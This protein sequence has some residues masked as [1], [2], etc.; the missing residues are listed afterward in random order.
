MIGLMPP[1]T[2]APVEAHHAEQVRVVGDRDRGHAQRLRP[3]DEGADPHHAVHEREL[4]MQMQVHEAGI[5]DAPRPGACR[6]SAD[7]T[8]AKLRRWIGEGPS[9]SRASRCAPRSIALVAR[10]SV[11]G[12]AAIHLDH[13]PVPGHLGENRRGADRRDGGV[14]SHHRPHR[15]GHVRATIPV[16]EDQIRR[17]VEPGDRFAHRLH[18]GLEDVDRIDDVDVGPRDRIACRPLPDLDL[19]RSA[20][21]CAERRL[22][23]PRPTIR[24][25]GS[26]ITA[27]ATTG[28][29]SGPAPRF[30]DACDEPF[31]LTAPRTACADARIHAPATSSTASA[32]FENASFRNAR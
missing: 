20:R 9:R 7:F 29:A 23:S 32:A 3:L 16:H 10:E 19:Q 31:R 18:R 25:A 14:A 5:H 30:I 17:R 28:P 24:T 6:M 8:G 2:A 21:C 22:E 4:G 12:I 1:A 11:L 13:L 15:T 27:A 26:R